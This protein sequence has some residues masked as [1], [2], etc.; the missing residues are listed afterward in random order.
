MPGPS[1]FATTQ[2]ARLIGTPDS[3]LILDVRTDE[4]FA[5]DP[6]SIPGAQRR[7]HRHVADWAAGSVGKDAVV[8]RQ[9]GAKLSEG[10]A[11]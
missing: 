1:T 3:P 10:V 9:R 5:R 7:D 6:R 11:A 2:L 4:D 8:V